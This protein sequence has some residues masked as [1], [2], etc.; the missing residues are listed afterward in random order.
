MDFLSYDSVNL[1]FQFIEFTMKKKIICALWILSVGGAWVYGQSAYISEV[2]EDARDSGDSLFSRIFAFIIF[3][4]VVWLVIQIRDKYKERKDREENILRE[5]N[6]S[7]KLASTYIQKNDNIS[8]FQSRQS[9]Q[10]GFAN[11]T[12]DILHNCVKDHN[13]KSVNDLIK[14]YRLECEM[15]H[16]IKAE[17]I[18]EKIGYFQKLE[19]YKSERNQRET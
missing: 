6:Y 12:Y 19:L 14:E 18:M 2:Y 1:N 4:G 9:W 8:K 13:G 17:S 11:A 7:A 3:F 5:R 15:G 10:K 16:M